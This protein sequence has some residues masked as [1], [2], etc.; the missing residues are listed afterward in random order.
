MLVN[1]LAI[2]LALALHLAIAF[3]LVRRYLRTRDIGFIWLGVAVV[4]WP[5][6]SRLLEAGE[7]VSIRNQSVIYPFSLIESGQ[8]T[9]GALVTSLALSQQLV[10]VCL[11]LIAVIYLAKAKSG[12]RTAA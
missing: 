1:T 7:R 4:V 3:I 6:I 5:L 10:G 11:L 9:A 8:M 12:S 2:I